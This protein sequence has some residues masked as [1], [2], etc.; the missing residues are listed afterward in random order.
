MQ[1]K[2]A[3]FDILLSKSDNENSLNSKWNCIKDEFLKRDEYKDRLKQME[4]M[5]EFS[6]TPEKL[7]KTAVTVANFCQEWI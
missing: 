2:T 3:A 4:S 5:M 1:D 6:R 7:S